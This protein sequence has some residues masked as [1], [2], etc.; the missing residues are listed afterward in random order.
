MSRKR[1]AITPEDKAA[2]RHLYER[3]G[4]TAREIARAVG[5]NANSIRSWISREGW[6]QDR[7]ETLATEARK[8]S[9]MTPEERA[10]DKNRKTLSLDSVTEREL[11]RRAVESM[12]DIG[13]QLDSIVK[14]ALD[15][16]EAMVEEAASPKE[17]KDA[18][19]AAQGAAG[20]YRLNNGVKDEQGLKVETG[21]GEIKFTIFQR[22][23]DVA[24]VP[25]SEGRGTDA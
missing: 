1:P 6:R 18:I 17:L 20:M 16:A 14:K 8:R 15:R 22:P 7:S 9:R 5:I 3:E 11:E 25:P 2:A 23:A 10:K 13:L 4:R 24:S 21:A 19:Q 12:A